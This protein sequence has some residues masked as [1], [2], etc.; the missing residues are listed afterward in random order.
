MT[1][2][3]MQAEHDRADDVDADA[4]AT[5]EVA[6]VLCARGAGAHA[7]AALLARLSG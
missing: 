5:V 1:P 2:Q 4:A 6:G 3:M 7:A